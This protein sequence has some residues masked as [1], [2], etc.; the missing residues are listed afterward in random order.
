MTPVDIR[1]L[2]K[3]ELGGIAPEVDLETIDPNGDLRAQTDLDSMDFLNLI[4]AIHQRL[5]IDIPE[6]DYPRL[7]SLEGFIDYLAQRS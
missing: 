7:A 4:T 1:A 5:G 2:I 6:S 3:D